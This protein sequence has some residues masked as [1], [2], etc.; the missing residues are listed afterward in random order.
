MKMLFYLFFKCS[1]KLGKVFYFMRHDLLRTISANS[2]LCF[3]YSKRNCLS[4]SLKSNIERRSNLQYTNI[5][6]NG[7]CM[8]KKCQKYFSVDNNMEL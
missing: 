6:A 7:P 8:K 5:E 2:S 4:H 3:K 1:F